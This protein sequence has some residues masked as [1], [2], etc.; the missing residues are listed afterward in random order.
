MLLISLNMTS[1]FS[2]FHQQTVQQRSTMMY[3]HSNIT[4]DNIFHWK[5][6]LRRMLLPPW[7]EKCKHT[8]PEYQVHIL[9]ILSTSSSSS[10]L[11]RLRIIVG[12][13]WGGI[14][15]IYNKQNILLRVHKTI[16]SASF[17][18]LE[19]KVKVSLLLL[20][21]LGCRC[22]P[23]R[24]KASFSREEFTQTPYP[25]ILIHSHYDVFQSH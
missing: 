5:S 9:Y 1:Y 2:I 20:L 17:F 10:S 25:Y 18:R 6:Y 3:L 4:H 24:N 23:V 7:W 12:P 11:Y 21:L 22:M 15:C 14:K 19:W 13:L 16:Y 8:M